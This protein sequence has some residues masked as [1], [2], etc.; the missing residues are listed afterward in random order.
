MVP[1]TQKQWVV[2]GSD[3]FD[4]L[5]FQTESPIPSIGDLDVLVQIHAVSLNF[6][7]VI[8]PRGLY[9][10][11]L[12]DGLVPLSDGAGIVVSVGSR[13]SRFIVGDRVATLFHQHHLAG[14][15][16]SRAL[17]SGLGGSF[18]GVLR[19]YAAFSE[20]GLVSIPGNL[21]LLEA[22]SLPCASLTAWSAL[23]GLEGRA[24]KP[25]DIVLTEGTGGVSS[26]AVQFAKAAGAK[27][28]STTSAADKAERLKELGADYVINYKENPNW[29]QIAKSLTPN[30]EGV[31]LV[32]EVGGPSTAR[33]AL[34]AVKLGGLIS[35]VGSIS[36][37]TSPGSDAKAPTFLDA[38]YSC[39]TVRAVTVGSR[40]QFEEMN[41]A[42][43]ANDIHPVLDERVLELDQAREAYQYLWD[44]KHLGKIV[45]RIAH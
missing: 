37:F 32:V 25:G 3:G 42:I 31:S 22:A 43:E 35:M 7:D 16:D 20:E 14:P 28:I 18:D 27:V 13:V 26:F 44:Q 4:S 24:L 45:L 15:L 9:P 11:P 5:Q 17:H 2:R 33:Q 8:I 10:F 23:Y 36:S 39:C 29:G 12:K 19:E 40:L 30:N 1:Q 6:R 38:V 41:R 21:S 34:I